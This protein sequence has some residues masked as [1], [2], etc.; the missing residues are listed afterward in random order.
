[1]A[2]IQLTGDTGAFVLDP[3]N[4]VV[5]VKRRWADD[6]TTENYLQPISANLSIAP[7]ISAA[8]FIYHYG[9]IKREDLNEFTVFDPANL[10]NQYVRIVVDDQ[11]VF[12]G[13]L[14]DDQ[15]DLM[16][17]LNGNPSGDQSMTAYG[18]EHL[19]D[20]AAVAGAETATGIIQFSPAFNL[21]EKYGG[22]ISGN[23]SAEPTEDGYYVFDNNDARWSNLDIL[24]YIINVHSDFGF[25]LGLSGQFDVLADVYGVYWFEGLTI[26]QVIDK[27]VD[28]RRG[29]GW[30]L[31]SNGENVSVHIFTVFER[32]IGFANVLIPGNPDQYEF[33]M[34][35]LDV[36][37]ATIS[38]SQSQ[39]YDRILVQG[40]RAQTVF[41]LSVSEGDL[42][43]AWNEQD[44][45]AYINVEGDTNEAKDDERQSDRFEAVF[46]R[47]MLSTD[48]DSR[49]GN[50]NGGQRSPVLPLLDSKANIIAESADKVMQIRRPFLRS[51]PFMDSKGQT[52]PPLVLVKLQVD[53]ADKWF[54]ID[55]GS[56]ALK[57][58]KSSVRMLDDEPGFTLKPAINH[59]LAAGNFFADTD[60][61]ETDAVV[62]YETLTATVSIE[63][64]TRPTVV[65]DITPDSDNTRTLV[66]TIYDAE[67]WYATPNTVTGVKD[68]RFE[69]HSGGVLRDDTDKLRYLAAL[70]AGWYS[71][72]R[73]AVT[74]TTNNLMASLRPGILIT[75]AA[76]SWHK[77]PVGTVLS[78]INFDF[79][80]RTTTLMTGHAE[81]DLQILLD[82][83]GMSDFRSVGRAFN[84][85]QAQIKQLSDRLGFMP[86]RHATASLPF[87]PAAEQ[88]L[89]AVDFIVDNFDR[90]DAD[91]LG[92]YW[93]DNAQNIYLIRSGA[94]IS[95]KLVQDVRNTVAGDGFLVASGSLTGHEII[96]ESYARLT[97]GGQVFS[98]TTNLGS[99]TAVANA[100]LRNPYA[101]NWAF[102]DIIHYKTPIKKC[103]GIYLELLV[104]VPDLDVVKF[105]YEVPGKWKIFPIIQEVLH[106][107]FFGGSI[108]EGNFDGE[109]LAFRVANF[110][111]TL[112]YVDAGAATNSSKTVTV[113]ASP[114]E[115]SILNNE[116]LATHVIYK[117]IAGEK[118][119]LCTDSEHV[120]IDKIVSSDINDSADLYSQSSVTGIDVL[121]S[122]HAELSGQ[123]KMLFHI[124]ND[125]VSLHLN[126]NLI[127]NVS[128]SQKTDFSGLIALA[129]S[130]SMLEQFGEYFH[131]I[132]RVRVWRDDIP[133]PPD[134]ESGHG[135]YNNETETFQYTDRYHSI[136][137]EGEAVYDPT[138]LD[139]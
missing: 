78:R 25:T 23:R 130:M 19:L 53:G 113:N 94:A 132:K 63:T 86:V 134:S 59:A 97:V 57:T 30:Y 37:K 105:F 90:G 139:D 109:S 13:V 99:V 28:R 127:F 41:T 133:E 7:D 137:E 131:G 87:D 108:S 24:R 48:W 121:S 12:I 58:A 10:A 128:V 1:M 123:A 88:E 118:I 129:P 51:L 73:S 70:A 84:R 65:V 36:Q 17:S 95:N 71:Q 47:F 49:A 106:G 3:E 102:G 20:R 122:G 60:N 114:V 92:S 39:L 80:N 101:V 83:P 126:N 27:L 111:K 43:P 52:I 8:S 55:A 22:I 15:F 38:Q 75:S 42:V 136:D 115:H 16:G 81:L 32:D 98:E 68:G 14:M 112:F 35:S 67:F 54:Q 46:Q 61:S 31:W 50:G 79:E 117:T 72:R 104:D 119:S 107:I 56:K 6:W 120:S 76:T 4:L 93:E 89:P 9:E 69:Q 40:A 5:Q 34:D 124:S 77:E 33:N 74:L 11:Q 45:Q 110:Y 103:S 96:S 135:Y 116:G 18:L 66:L 2:S 64:D 29:L 91:N 138:A 62:D 100:R 82:I 85:Q 44:K 21:A 26:R 125:V